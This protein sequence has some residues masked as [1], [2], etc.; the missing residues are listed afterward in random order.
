MNAQWLSYFRNYAENIFPTI[1]TPV[2]WSYKDDITMRGEEMLLAL[3]GDG[4]YRASM[5]KAGEALLTPEG[6]LRNWDDTVHNL[7]SVSLGKSL[8]V[9]YRLTGNEAIHGEILRVRRNLEGHPRTKTGNYWHKNIYPWQVWLDGL[10]MALP[11]QAETDIDRGVT[12]F[13]DI[14][15]QFR[16]VRAHHFVR[17]T[18]LYL[19]A[20]D[21]SRAMDWCDPATGLSRCYWLRAEGWLLMAMCD[22]YELLRDRAP[23]AGLFAGLLREAADGILPYQDRETRMFCQLIDLK[24]MAGNYPETSGSAMVAYALLKGARLGMLDRGYAEKGAEI[25]EGIRRTYLT[26]EDIPV[27]HGICASAGLG[28]GPDNRTDRDGTPRYYLSEKQ[29]PDNQHGTAACM[30]AA[31]ECIRAGM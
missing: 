18:G 19:H 13:S 23:D 3:T 24:D 27:L 12:D 25:L 31:A 17:E 20:W 21:E 7:D 9:L 6:R 1:P 16:Q 22:C 8:W 29:S 4:A 10:Y 30:M 28:P 2:H 26:G 15:E 5:L 14:L 11:F